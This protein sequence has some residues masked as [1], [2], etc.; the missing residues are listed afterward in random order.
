MICIVHVPARLVA[1]ADHPSVLIGR[2]LASALVV[3]AQREA[4]ALAVDVHAHAR[5]AGGHRTRALTAHKGKA[6]QVT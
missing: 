3:G 6:A 1:R 2:R 4:H 5:F